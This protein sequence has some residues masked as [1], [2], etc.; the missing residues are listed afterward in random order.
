M[1]ICKG[2]LIKIFIPVRSSIRF[3]NL[4]I[5]I[6]LLL[7][8][9]LPIKQGNYK[10]ECDGILE[11]KIIILGDFLEYKI[12]TDMF[13]MQIKILMA[14]NSNGQVSEKLLV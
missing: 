13:D 12:T 3:M 7:E 14:K 1:F 6:F 8:I 11:I 9:C 2:G 5:L 4:A 10:A